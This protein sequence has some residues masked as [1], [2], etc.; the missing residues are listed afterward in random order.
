MR[1]DDGNL[2]NQVIMCTAG[3]GAK[4]RL[5]GWQ[6]ETLEKKTSKPKIAFREREREEGEKW[7]WGSCTGNSGA[8]GRNS[9][10]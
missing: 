3:C 6:N 2:G 10:R 8:G 7:W 9:R 4:T 5:R 1:L